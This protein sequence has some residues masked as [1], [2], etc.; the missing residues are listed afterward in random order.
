ME[1]SHIEYKLTSSIN[2]NIF[3]ELS[4]LVDADSLFYG[5]FDYNKT[6]VWAGHTSLSHTDQLK[7]ELL[8]NEIKIRKVKIGILNS[9]HTIIPN[10]EFNTDT[11]RDIVTHVNHIDQPEQYIYRSEYSVQHKLRVLYAVQKEVIRTLNAA[12]DNCQ[13]IHVNFAQVE[14]TSNGGVTQDYTVRLC[15]YESIFCLTIVDKEQLILC[16]TYDYS[17]NQDVLYFLGLAFERLGLDPSTQSVEVGGYV[18]H[19]GDLLSELKRYFGGIRYATGYIKSKLKSS[20]E[21]YHLPLYM[22]SKCA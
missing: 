18:T 11:I 22:I 9:Q 20:E 19:D 1:L 3:Y 13:L 12:F 10:G 21:H 4:A 2:K 5:V 8:D 6:L 14:S 7:Q 17:R 15:F 16:N